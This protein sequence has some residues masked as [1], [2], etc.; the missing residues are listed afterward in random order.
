MF[1][2]PRLM[3]AYKVAQLDRCVATIGGEFSFGSVLCSFMFERVVLL[4]PQD[5]LDL[6]TTQDP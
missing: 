6:P 5:I 1:A 4:R 2:Q 3:C